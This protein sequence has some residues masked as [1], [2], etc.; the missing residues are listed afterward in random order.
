MK[1]EKGERMGCLGAWK[2]A[3]FGGAAF[4][5]N[6]MLEMTFRTSALFLHRHDAAVAFMAAHLLAFTR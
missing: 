2:G 4:V 3:F 5:C 6:D 1:L